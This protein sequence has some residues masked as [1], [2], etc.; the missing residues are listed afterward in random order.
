[1]NCGCPA[2]YGSNIFLKQYFTY[3]N[4]LCIFAASDICKICCVKPNST[5]ACHPILINATKLN[6]NDGGP[7]DTGSFTGTCQ[8]VCSVLLPNAHAR[9]QCSVYFS[10]V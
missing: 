10:A 4:S 7:C 2:Q 5:E 8:S 6:V 3:D 1:M 9:C